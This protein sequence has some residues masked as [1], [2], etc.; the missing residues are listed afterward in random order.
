M[1]NIRL[2]SRYAKSLLDLAIEK[3]QLE[4]VYADVKV[5]DKAI[6]GSAELA[7]LLKSP[8]INSGKKLD[9]LKAIFSSKVNPI[10]L[11]FIEILVKKGREP[12]LI[13]MAHSFINQYNK[14]KNITPVKVTTATAIDKSTI[15]NILAQLKAKT[16]IVNVELST[17][18]DPELI[19][20]F[21]LQF[22]D[23]MFDASVS[24]KLELLEKEFNKNVYVKDF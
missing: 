11:A 24:R 3:G 4:Q 7:A 17:E 20:G 16:G 23:K 8:I 1:S 6:E 21:V 19:G 15:D 14:H 22:E 2:S 13:D 12:Y 5:I 10:T 18:V 9:V